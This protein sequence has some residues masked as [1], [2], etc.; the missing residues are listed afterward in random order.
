MTITVLVVVLD[1]D[2]RTTFDNTA[3]V[4]SVG[5]A[6][7]VASRLSTEGTAKADSL[8]TESSDVLT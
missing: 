5:G 1:W 8:D 3:K 6:I 7:V 2:D 4:P